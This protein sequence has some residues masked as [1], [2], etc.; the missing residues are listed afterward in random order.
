[1]SEQILNINKEKS[2]L[3]DKNLNQEKN[4][5]LE[6]NETENNNVAVN[7]INNEIQNTENIP[8]QLNEKETYELPPETIEKLNLH[9]E[10]VNQ[11][12]SFCIS[13]KLMLLLIP[14]QNILKNQQIIMTNFRM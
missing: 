14:N 7:N 3:F 6:T 12:I 5:P 9:V 1:M 11:K 2:D 13:Q 8:L 10:Y 4:K